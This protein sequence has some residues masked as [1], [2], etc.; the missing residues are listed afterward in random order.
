MALHMHKIGYLAMEIKNNL[1]VKVKRYRSEAIASIDPL[2]SK[3]IN[4]VEG[5]SFGDIISE[6]RTIVEFLR[7][8]ITTTVKDS[9]FDPLKSNYHIVNE[10]R[11]DKEICEAFRRLLLVSYWRDITAFTDFNLYPSNLK[12]FKWLDPIFAINYN[13][14]LKNIRNYRIDYSCY[15]F[16]KHILEEKQLVL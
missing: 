9:E 1:Q 13:E 11:E 4:Y 7:R 8:K 15:Y 6:E 16:I 10:L 12:P 14:D 2:L 5:K 3:Y